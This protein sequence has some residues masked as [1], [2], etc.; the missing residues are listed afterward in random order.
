MRGEEGNQAQ[1]TATIREVLTEPQYR[2][3]RFK[4]ITLAGHLTK[5]ERTILT[6]YF[7]EQEK[8]RQIKEAFEY[9]MRNKAVVMGGAA[10][11][12]D[13][14]EHY[15]IAYGA[16]GDTKATNPKDA[17]GGSKLP[18]HL[19]PSVATVL[20]CLGL[21]DGSLKYGRQNWRAAGVKYSIYLDAAMRHL[22]AAW[23]G[24]DNDPDSGL[25]H[26]AHVL[27]CMAIIVDA[28][29]NGKLT[30]DRAYVEH[31]SYQRY[32][33]FINAMTFHVDRLKE[34]Y[35]LR[36]PRHYTRQDSQGTNPCGTAADLPY[37]NAGQPARTEGGPSCEIRNR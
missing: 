20:G 11:S 31:A 7:E 12:E 32:R 23:E 18:I 25:P 34:K 9:E 33:G 16:K 35:N 1:V 6:A 17:I 29:T 22:M 19:W 14:I 36:S 30:D 13:L 21:L 15:P 37:A 26:E 2:D 3:T 27:A 10:R 4:M 28:R 24:E 8:E 5:V